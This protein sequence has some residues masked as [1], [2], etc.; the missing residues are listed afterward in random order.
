ML[1]EN[2]RFKPARKEE[3]ADLKGKH[4][5]C[6]NCGEYTIFAKVQ[7]ADTKCSMCGSQMI[8]VDMATASK[9]T[10]R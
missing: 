2:G 4:M 10:G 6:P 9:A 1:K 7:F 5:K 8:D 3:L